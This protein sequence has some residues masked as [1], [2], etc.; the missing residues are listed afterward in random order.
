MPPKR[1]VRCADV[2]IPEGRIAE[3]R[4]AGAGDAEVLVTEVGA[5]EVRLYFGMFYPPPTPQCYS[6]VE[7]CS[8]HAPAL[9]SLRSCEKALS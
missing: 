4:I 9:R 5:A 8:L 2:R 1:E 7:R 6:G 3:V